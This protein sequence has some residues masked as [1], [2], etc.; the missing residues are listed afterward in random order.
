MQTTPKMPPGIELRRGEA[1]T[2]SYRLTAWHYS[3][4]DLPAAQRTD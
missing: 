3:K 2:L 4:A 1:C